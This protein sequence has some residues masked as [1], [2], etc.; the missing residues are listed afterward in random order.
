MARVCVF[1]VIGSGRFT[2][3]SNW[4]GSCLCVSSAPS[5]AAQGARLVRWSV[6]TPPCSRVFTAMPNDDRKSDERATDIPVMTT[7]TTSST[8]TATWLAAAAVVSPTTTTADLWNPDPRSACRR[9]RAPTSRSTVTIET[10]GRGSRWRWRRRWPLPRSACSRTSGVSS[11]T[12][13]FCQAFVLTLLKS[14]LKSHLF[15]SAY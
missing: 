12:L 6:S 4:R 3:G 14:E 8:T 7:A 15:S 9:V 5:R 11:G 1:L 10:A 2:V 13:F